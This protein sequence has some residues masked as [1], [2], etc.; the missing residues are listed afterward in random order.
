MTCRV[1]IDMGGAYNDCDPRPP[2][3]ADVRESIY[4]Y[5]TTLIHAWACTLTNHEIEL[6]ARYD[7]QPAEPGTLF[8]W[9]VFAE[10]RQ[11]EEE[12]DILASIVESLSN[13]ELPSRLLPHHQDL[14]AASADLADRLD[15]FDQDF[16]GQGGAD[17]RRSNLGFVQRALG[18]IRRAIQAAHTRVGV[19]YADPQ[20]CEGL[21]R[22]S[23]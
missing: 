2:P 15:Q 7:S 13:K 12:G 19:L 8:F 1:L 10:F 11:L 20:A 4:L 22:E 14:V 17:S 5:N 9:Q 16:I 23:A 6:N 18:D 21:P 3:L